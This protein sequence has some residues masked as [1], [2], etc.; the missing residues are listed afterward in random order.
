MIDKFHGLLS[1]ADITCLRH[2][3]TA[4]YDRFAHVRIRQAACRD[5][6]ADVALV[7]TCHSMYLTVTAIGGNTN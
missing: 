7:A 1:V 5:G 3:A 6:I 2:K 4:P